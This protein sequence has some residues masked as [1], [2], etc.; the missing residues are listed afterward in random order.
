[1]AKSDLVDVIVAFIGLGENQSHATILFCGGGA[2][3]CLELS[4]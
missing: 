4:Q 3:K 2:K 1:M